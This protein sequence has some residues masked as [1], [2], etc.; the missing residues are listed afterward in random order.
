M[1]DNKFDKK[2]LKVL[3]QHHKENPKMGMQASDIAREGKMN[4]ATTTRRLL[5]LALDKRVKRVT[6]NFLGDIKTVWDVPEAVWKVE[7]YV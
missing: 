3:K 2:I 6:V 1:V 4:L 7:D 5:M